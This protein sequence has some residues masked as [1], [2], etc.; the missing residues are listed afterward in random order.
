MDPGVGVVVGVDV[1]E[2]RGQSGGRGEWGGEGHVL[3][4][5]SVH[6]SVLV[7]DAVLFVRTE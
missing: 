7:D 4:L 3:G 2:T 6:S 1:N 5:D